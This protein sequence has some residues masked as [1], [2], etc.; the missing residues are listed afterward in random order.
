MKKAIVFS[1][2]VA[3]AA[4]NSKTDHKILADLSAQRDSLQQ[5]QISIE[6]QLN[7]VNMQIAEEDSS[8]NPND[9][10]LIK[11]ITLQKNKIAGIEEK[12]KGLENKMT[13]R[14]E[15]NLLPV[16]VKEIKNETFNHNII[17][18]GEV[19]AKN[20][21]KIS[22]E[23]NGRIE[24][25]LV[26]EGQRVLQGQVLVTLNTDALNRQMEGIKSGLEL[27]NKTYQKLDTLWK[28]NIGSEIDF[29]AARNTKV[30]LESQLEALQAQKRMAQIRAPFDGVV[31]QIYPKVGEMAGPG[32][33]VIEFVNLNKLI[34]KAN[35]SESYIT[36]IHAGQIV[37]LS[38]SSIPDFKVKTPIVRI[39]KVISSISRT[40]E[41]EMKIDNP[42]E[43]IKPNMVSTILINDFSSNNAFVV[44]S[45]V[46]RKDITGRYVYVV[47]PEKNTFVVEKKYIT[48]GLSYN[49]NTMITQG[50]NAGDQVIVK[51]YHL[52][53]AG[54]P[55]N[56]V[57]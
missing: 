41:I 46:I 53:S 33:P 30:S 48:T 6:K 49:D 27:A 32:F 44:P 54:V 2:I 28:Q 47:H 17:A 10:K 1:L 18:Y 52:V 3:L 4:C 34:I 56:L 13:A 9:L 8:V 51:G 25:I 36:S 15:N 11:L 42:N 55:V 45:L 21:A 39:S 14:E 23:M 20:Y 37:E 5:M 12:I 43:I 7:L 22:P 29:L 50:L 31:N 19:E 16:A 24:K 26:S 57:K 35:V 40:F 38:F